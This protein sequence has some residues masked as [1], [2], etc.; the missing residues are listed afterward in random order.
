MKK[1]LTL[2][3]VAAMATAVFAGCS[4][5]E[6][7]ESYQGEEISFRTRTETRATEIT[8]KNL[9]SFYVWGDAE[10]YDDF[11]LQRGIATRMAQ[12]DDNTAT[13]DLK[14][15]DG[16]KVYWPAG[17]TKIDFWAYGPKD[18]I[19]ESQEEVTK[20]HQ[21]LEYAPAVSMTEG[22]KSHK[23]LIVAHTTATHQTSG[24]NVTL[25][26]KHPLSGITLDLQSGDPTKIM[27]LK[28]AWFVNAK[29]KGI[30]YYDANA[31]NQLINWDLAQA[32]NASYGVTTDLTIYNSSA[33]SVITK[34]N[35]DLMLIPQNVNKLVF[36][37]NGNIT[38][39]GSYILLLCQIIS[40]HTGAQHT[41]ETTAAEDNN[42][43][44][45]HLLF[46]EDNSAVFESINKVPTKYAYTCVPVDF[47]WEAGKRYKYSLKFCGTNS[48]GG[49]YP[50]ATLPEL[51]EVSGVEI[52]D[53]PDTK[54]PGSPVLDNPITF[55][56]SVA[57]WDDI[58]NDTNLQ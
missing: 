25:D 56:V 33:T 55:T 6:I 28:G 14:T 7:L 49:I 57:G 5:D 27:R 8:I 16:Y 29:N 53:R 9:E 21:R 10:N 54:N 42:A 45:Y 30:L 38:T 31:T 11:F 40:E 4:S 19:H 23:D 32:S 51:P 18:I 15:K 50:P 12:G 36:D 47:S 43:K 39:N 44:H 34:G 2:L 3:G 13:Y 48:G 41:D 24:A 37:G 1:H 35:N 22:G 17:V 52:I 46:P 26:F 20:Q 58:T